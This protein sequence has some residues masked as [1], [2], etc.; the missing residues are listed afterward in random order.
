[1]A[2]ALAPSSH[3][4]STAFNRSATGSSDG[5]P[6]PITPGDRQLKEVLAIGLNPHQI[7]PA[8]ALALTLALGAAVPAAASARLDLN[9][10]RAPSTSPRPAVQIV[11]VSAPGGFDWGDAAIGAAGA[12]GL[13]MLALGGGAVITARRRQTPHTSSP[14]H[15]TS[16]HQEGTGDLSRAPDTKSNLV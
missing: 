9:P 6:D 11:R 7:K 8:L 1:V 15:G 4:V 16:P 12:L 14:Q 10:Q 13:S 5:F 2:Q 3:R